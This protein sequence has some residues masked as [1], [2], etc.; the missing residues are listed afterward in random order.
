MIK[1]LAKFNVI[2]LILALISPFF[3]PVDP[4]VAV[5]CGFLL[6]LIFVLSSAWI[7][8]NFWNAD[9]K[10]FLKVFFFSMVIRFLL[11]LAAM[12]IL[13]GLTKIDEIYFTVSFIISYL[14]QSI[15]E[16][17]F[18]NQLLQNKSSN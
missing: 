16:M 9:S 12:G 5:I 6:S 15:T 17:I 8:D 14:Y 1:K 18:F 4:A 13:L 3:L 10:L 11:V 2:P 7:L